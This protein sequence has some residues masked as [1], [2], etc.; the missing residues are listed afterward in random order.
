MAQAMLAQTTDDESRKDWEKRLLEVRVERYL[1]RID[2]AS[3]SYRARRGRNPASI[4]ALVESGELP[5]PPPEPSGGRWELE[6]TTGLARSTAT[7]RLRVR[8][9]HGATAGLEVH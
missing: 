3:A 5:P 8:G 2:A 1:T 7:P 6:P 9:R 4:Q